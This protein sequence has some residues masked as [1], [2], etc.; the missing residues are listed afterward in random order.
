MRC[1][2]CANQGDKV[3]DSRLLP[4]GDAIR[5]RR[6]CESCGHRY[7]TYERMEVLQLVVVKK[8][9]Q[10]EVF[11]REKLLSGMLTALHRRPVPADE[12]HVFV[13]DLETRFLE[14]ST[15][16]VPSAELGEAVMGFLRARD[17]VAFVRFAS[18]YRE[19]RDLSDLLG[20]VQALADDRA[21]EPS[22]AV[23]AAPNPTP[24]DAAS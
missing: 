4:P 23:D 18:V 5:R 14:S 13:R 7:T 11:V 10:R 16:E 24:E 22:A 21:S 12:C 1:P 20:Q 8:N 3:I 6:E 19:F 17:P 2:R 9:G 15:R